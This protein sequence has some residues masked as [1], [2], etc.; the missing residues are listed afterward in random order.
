M[1]TFKF[2]TSLNDDTSIDAIKPYF[3]YKT[4]IKHW[5]V[6]MENPDKVLTITTDFSEKEIFEMLKSLGFSAEKL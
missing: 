4:K 5:E 1:K 6:D 2:K 3:N